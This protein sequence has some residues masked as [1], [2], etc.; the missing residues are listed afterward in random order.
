ME[1]EELS[2]ICIKVVDERKG[3]DESVEVL[4]GVVYMMKSKGP[5]T[6]PQGTPQ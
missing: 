4:R 5:K 2:I 1:G 6:G 3:R